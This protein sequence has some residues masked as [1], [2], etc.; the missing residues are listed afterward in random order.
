[1]FAFRSSD[2][3]LRAD[4]ARPLNSKTPSRGHRGFGKRVVE[5][6]AGGVVVRVSTGAAR[7][8]LIRDPYRKWGLPKGHLEAGEGSQDAALREVMEE[9]GLSDLKLGADLGE[10]DWTFRKS[11]RLVHKFCRFY[12]MESS[13]GETIPEASEGITECRWLSL[14]E[15]LQTIS[16]D[17]ARAILQRGVDR[18]R[19]GDRDE[20]GAGGS[21]LSED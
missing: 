4:E 18:L 10:I 9:T 7:V 6:S 11:G 3:R 19:D 21:F 8:L 12:L 20:A 17:N 14:E 5:R 13:R 2:G 15:A 16:Y 1:M